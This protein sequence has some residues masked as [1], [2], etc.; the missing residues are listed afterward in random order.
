MYRCMWS[1]EDAEVQQPATLHDTCRRH[2][3]TAAGFAA[4]DTSSTHA[5]SSSCMMYRHYMARPRLT[6]PLYCNLAPSQRAI[7]HF[8]VQQSN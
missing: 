7:T 6:M 1:D 8:R 4:T 3:G 5:I 2:N